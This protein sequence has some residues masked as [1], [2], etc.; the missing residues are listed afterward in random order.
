MKTFKKVLLWILGIVVVLILVAGYFGLVPGVSAIFGSNKAKNLGVVASVE[1][2]NSANTKLA[3]MRSGDATKAERISYS[4][5]H[6]ADVSLTSEELTSLI[7]EGTWKNNPISEDLQI[8]IG[9]AG[10][11]QVSGLLNRTKLDGYLNATGFSD[12]TKY[13]KSFS[14]L[15]E[16]VPFYLDGTA[17]VTNNKVDLNVKSAELGRVPLPTD[18]N[19]VNGVESFIMQRMSKVTGLNVISLDFKNGK[20]NFKGTFPSK[21]SY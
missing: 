13:T 21:I 14:A 15:P 1:A 5:S 3:L 10:D 2:F 8:K 6:S 12:A 11:V 19:T 4:G 18:S 17:S 7:A 16:K 9:D 20:L